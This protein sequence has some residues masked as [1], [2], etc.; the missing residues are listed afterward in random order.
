MTL[1]SP[2]ATALVSSF[3]DKVL[4]K[5]KKIFYTLHPRPNFSGTPSMEVW[6]QSPP[7]EIFT[8]VWLSNPMDTF[9]SS[10]D[11]ISLSI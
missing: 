4:Q 5:K 10:K 11:L 1:H 9:L 7:N 3:S 8:K 2:P 6:H